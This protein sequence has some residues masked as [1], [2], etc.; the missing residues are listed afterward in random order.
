MAVFI[1]KL[2]QTK[3]WLLWSVLM[4]NFDRRLKLGIMNEKMRRC[5]NFTR[6]IIT[7]WI[8]LQFAGWANFTAIQASC[9][10][11]SMLEQENHSQH[12]GEA[13]M[14]CCKKKAATQNSED[15]LITGVLISCQSSCLISKLKQQP[16]NLPAQVEKIKVFEFQSSAIGQDIK[17]PN[18]HENHIVS[19]RILSTKSPPLFLL[20][21][22]FLI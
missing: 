16:T 15:T 3:F 10:C 2:T 7:W 17:L 8:L 22:A 18:I 13:A 11:C 9:R 12:S 5:M 1:T 21:S 4:N 19:N 14:S 20:N 6:K